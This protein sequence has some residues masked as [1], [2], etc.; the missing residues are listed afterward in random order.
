MVRVL[1]KKAGFLPLV[2]GIAFTPHGNW[3]ISADISP[4]AAAV[5]TAHEGYELVEEANETTDE[6]TDEKG[7]A[8]AVNNAPMPKES[9]AERRERLK[10][11]AAA[12]SAHKREE[13][14]DVPPVSEVGAVSVTDEPPA[15]G[16]VSPSL[17]F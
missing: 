10:R 9:A 3:S 11:E 16:N 6:T 7:G 2:N 12:E 5:L 4:E 15:D 8:A 13:A 1:R 17:E 14:V